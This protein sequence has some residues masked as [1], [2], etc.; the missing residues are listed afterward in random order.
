MSNRLE[1]SAISEMSEISALVAPETLEVM[2]QQL[3]EFM[4]SLIDLEAPDDP[5]FNRL[6]DIAQAMEAKGQKMSGVMGSRRKGALL[7][8]LASALSSFKRNVG[9][10][11]L[12]SCLSTAFLGVSGEGEEPSPELVAKAREGI[13]RLES[14]M[15]CPDAPLTARAGVSKF[16]SALMVWNVEC[17]AE[18][19]DYY[20]TPQLDMLVQ[21]IGWP[22]EWPRLSR[23]C[24]HVKG[25]VL[26][27]DDIL[28]EPKAEQMLLGLG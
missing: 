26:P 3:T 21:K 15:G 14:Q 28:P 11:F 10:S 9:A 20:F 4:E 16:L 19:R 25:I 24:D 13:S 6:G 22:E 18:E 17:P 27:E 23:F 12:G 8:E 5:T 2:P 7:L 1:I